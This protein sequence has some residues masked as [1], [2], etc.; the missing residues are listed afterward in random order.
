IVPFRVR[1]S[2]TAAQVALSV[3]Y[4]NLAVRHY[5][6]DLTRGNLIGTGGGTVA[7]PTGF[8]VV[9]PAGALSQPVPVP[10]PQLTPP[11]AP[12][13]I[14]SGYHLVAAI[15]L[16]LGGQTLTQPAALKWASATDPTGS[17]LIWA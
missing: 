11:A 4:E 14:P 2:A 1:P 9:I 15:Q 13:A 10:P 6:A 12:V 17:G 7:G 3:G 8:S 16:A 5:A